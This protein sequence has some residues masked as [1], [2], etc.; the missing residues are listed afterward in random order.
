MDR[1]SRIRLAVALA[2]LELLAGL[3]LIIQ[4]GALLSVDRPV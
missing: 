1:P 2:S 4:G 3:L